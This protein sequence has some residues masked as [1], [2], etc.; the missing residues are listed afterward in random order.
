MA[1]GIS[2][3]LANGWLNTLRGTAF[4]GIANVYAKAHLGDPGAAGSANPS[5]QTTRVAVTW[6]V[7]AGGIIV[8]SNAPEFTLN[9]TETIVGCSFWDNLTAGNFLFSAQATVSKGGV[10]ADI[11]RIATLPVSL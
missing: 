2:P 7:A 9:A 3:Y 10:S 5:A 1:Y 6:S 8:L 4:A 11:I